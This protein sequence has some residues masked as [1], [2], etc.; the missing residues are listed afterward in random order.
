[1]PRKPAAGGGGDAG[2]SRAKRDRAIRP[3]PGKK[4]RTNPRLSVA[5]IGAGRL[6]TALARALAACGYTIEALVARRL[7]RAQRA[8]T[9]VGS[10]TGRARPAVLSSAQLDRLPPVDLLFITTPDDA[11]EDVAAQLAA[12][13]SQRD[14]ATPAASLRKRRV[15]LHTSGALA[16]SAL[17]ALR[18]PGFAIGS[19][20]PLA[21]VSDPLT[22]AENLRGAFYCLE[23]DKRAVALGRRI[24]RDLKGQS[25]SIEARDK[26]LYHAAA[27]M[28]SGHT[29]ALFDVATELL[30][31]CGL[32]PARAR[33]VL[34]P[35]LRST[36]INLSVQDQAH[37]LT[38]TF[39]RADVA[40]VRKHLAAL[41]A[42]RVREASSVYALLGERS[43][44][45]AAGRKGQDRA[46]LQEIAHAL[47]E[48]KD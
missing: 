18:A 32:T 47:E 27:V 17:D 5:I 28:T 23:G 21:S 41:G 1:M 30:T 25:F 44:R 40:T 31:R 20:H 48:A 35:L 15:A 24:V 39:A 14:A 4:S 26:S 12:A 10:H 9:F 42:A 38:G 3:H 36:L 22:G 43:L 6:G 7:K 2:P 13:L 29:V 33:R 8:A 11:I 19:L 34:L 37:A 45:L 16:S 46:V